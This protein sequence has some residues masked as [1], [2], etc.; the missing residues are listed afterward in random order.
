MSYFWKPEGP[1]TDFEQQLATSQ[2]DPGAWWHFTTQAGRAFDLLTCNPPY[3][4]TA[5]MEALPT[6][7][8]YEP[9]TALDGGEDGLRYY[10]AV[11]TYAPMILKPDGVLLF[12][13]GYDQA[14]DVRAILEEKGYH[15][16]VIRDYGQ[17][18]RVV[19]AKRA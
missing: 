1:A 17:N 16:A 7:V 5:E 19:L 11:A 6:D 15:T 10:R 12:E 3:I 18:D 14:E 9:E 8:R 2:Y 4:P 13:I